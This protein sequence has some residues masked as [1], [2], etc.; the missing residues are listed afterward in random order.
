MFVKIQKTLKDFL[1]NLFSFFL[2]I[3]AKECLLD[4]GHNLIETF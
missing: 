1:F 2:N 3:R 4:Q